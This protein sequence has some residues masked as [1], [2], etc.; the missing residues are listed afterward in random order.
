MLRARLLTAAVG[1]PLLV[2]LV[3]YAPQ[4]LFAWVMIV[5]T[6]L[7]LWEYF[8]LTQTRLSLS[9]GVATAWGSGVAVA[10][11]F[12]SETGVFATFLCGFFLCFS[13]SLRDANPT[14][15]I[16]GLALVVLGVVYVGM[17]L[18]HCILL[19]QHASG[20]SWIFFLLLVVMMSDSAA[21]AAGRLWGTRKLLPHI[22]PGK[23]IEGSCGAI[24]GTLVAAGLSWWWLLP[25][26][27]VLELTLLAVGL[28][29]V[30]QLGDLCESALKRACGAKDS[31]RIFPG[32]GGVLD[33][34]DSLLFSSAFLYYY[35]TV[36]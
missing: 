22:S 12:T 3:G 17:L 2:V 21:Y 35:V 32:H 34:L 8:S 4:W 10:M 23:T 28:G 33:R 5:F 24:V 26:R 1:I 13:L 6:A 15:A 11:V 27:S 19:R 20:I 31:G 14:N 36:W 29:V 25:E 30:A 9:R 7:G 18:P 16:S